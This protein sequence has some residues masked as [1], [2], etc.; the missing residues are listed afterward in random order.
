MKKL[1]K[2]TGIAGA[3]LI[4]ITVFCLKNKRKVAK[5]CTK[6]E[7]DAAKGKQTGTEKASSEE[8]YTGT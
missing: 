7:A 8:M 4:A 2:I 1:K 6:K 5:K 3:A